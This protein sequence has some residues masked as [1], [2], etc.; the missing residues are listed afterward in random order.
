MRGSPKKSFS[1]IID[2]GAQTWGELQGGKCYTEI[3]K[4]IV[5]NL[6][7]VEKGAKQLSIPRTS[8]LIGTKNE[9]TT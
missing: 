8:T 2:C 4:Y 1:N 3:W 7:Y 6:H 5:P 9:R